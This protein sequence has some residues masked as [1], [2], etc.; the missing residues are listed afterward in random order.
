MLGTSNKIDSVEQYLEQPVNKLVMVV[1][2][3]ESWIWFPDR[4]K[5]SRCLEHLEGSQMLRGST[6]LEAGYSLR[7]YRNDFDLGKYFKVVTCL[8]KACLVLIYW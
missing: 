6:C 5:G 7:D 3:D 4:A 2:I 1:K 8:W